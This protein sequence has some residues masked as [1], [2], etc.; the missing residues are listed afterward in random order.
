[1]DMKEVKATLVYGDGVETW[2]R[3]VERFMNM[4]V[5]CDYV[6]RNKDRILCVTIA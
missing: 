2:T 6:T 5:F 4:Q 3:G 1:M